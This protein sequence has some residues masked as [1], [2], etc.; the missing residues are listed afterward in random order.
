M[1]VRG[2]K[3]KKKKSRKNIR[4]KKRTRMHQENNIL[5]KQWAKKENHT[6]SMQTENPHVQA[7]GKTM[8]KALPA[9]PFIVQTVVVF[10]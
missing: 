10:K 4:A 7:H 8:I 2:G 3:A 5:H 9:S 6:K 1:K